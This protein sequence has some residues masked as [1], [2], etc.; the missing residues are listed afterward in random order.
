MGVVGRALFEVTHR[1]RRSRSL[2]LL[3][4]IRRAPRAARERA[5]ARQLELLRALLA[6]AESHVPYYRELFRANGIRSAEIRTLADFET[7]PILTKDIIRTNAQSLIADT[8]SADRLLRY[9]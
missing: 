2:E 4:E 6:H 5:L 3:A 8:T 9:N 7:V 1:L